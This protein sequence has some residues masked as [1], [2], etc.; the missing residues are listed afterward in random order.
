MATRTVFSS[1]RRSGPSRQGG[2]IRRKR[3]WAR[4]INQATAV[5]N[6]SP[7]LFRPLTNFRTDSGI[8]KGP[9]GAT[10]GGI[11]LSGLAFA[12]AVVD[13]TSTLTLAALVT[14]EEDVTEVDGPLDA[15][16]FHDDWM[17]WKTLHVRTI[18]V[19]T[20]I[21][22]PGGELQ[23]R[24]MRKFEELND[25]LVLV[26]QPFSGTW[27]LNYQISVLLLLP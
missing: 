12:T 16:N 7:N 5:T 20:H 6:A 15:G 11:R 25:D 13:A 17:L 27:S 9:A 14:N 4:A 19:E 23:V 26:S 24:S 3:V 8:L 21:E 2:S 1:A 10:I 18:N 22:G